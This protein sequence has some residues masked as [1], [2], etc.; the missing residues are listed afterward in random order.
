MIISYEAMKQ[1]GWDTLELSLVV[2]PVVPAVLS[3]LVVLIYETTSQ[4]IDKKS[5]VPLLMIAAT[6][7]IALVVEVIVLA[8]RV[9]G[10]TAS[11]L[12]VLFTTR[13]C[14]WRWIAN[15]LTCLNEHL[16]AAFPSDSSACNIFLK[17]NLRCTLEL[18]IAGYAWLMDFLLGAMLQACALLLSFV[19]ILSTL[20]LDCL[21]RTSAAHLV[22]SAEQQRMGSHELS[23]EIG[24]PKKPSTFQSLVE[25]LLQKSVSVFQLNT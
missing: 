1:Y 11:H 4:L 6:F 22:K 20:H 9:P 14:S 5:H 7:F 2:L 23:S 18:T 10:L 17:R 12:V 21:F 16:K 3:A 13:Y 15:S 19:P 25:G 8:F 24:S